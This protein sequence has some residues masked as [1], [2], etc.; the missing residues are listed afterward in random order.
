M[1]RP[2]TKLSPRMRMAWRSAW[3]MSGSP[4]RA[5]SRLRVAA[6]PEPFSSPSL[7]TRPVSIRP[8]VEALTRRLSEAPRCFSQRPPPIFS[9]ISRSAVSASGMRSS[10]SARHIRMMPSSEESAYWCMKASTP[11][12]SWR[13][14]RAAVTRRDARSATSRR[15]WGVAFAL[16]PSLATSSTS[17]ARN[18]RAIS[19]RAGG[20]RA[21]ACAIRVSPAGRMFCA[22]FFCHPA[23]RDAR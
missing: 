14:A 10:A 18:A 3:R 15:S 8:K 17:S 7:T 16:L 9:A 12:C 1:V 22:P 19:S 2:S 5:I 4:E 20:C 6:G 21:P 11:P 23:P 13:L